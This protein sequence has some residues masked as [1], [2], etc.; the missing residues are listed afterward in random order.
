MSNQKGN[1]L[2]YS[3]M[4]NINNLSS[5]ENNATEV[6]LGYTIWTI[7]LTLEMTQR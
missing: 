6:S 5:R 7:K 1:N 4:K 2:V 3:E